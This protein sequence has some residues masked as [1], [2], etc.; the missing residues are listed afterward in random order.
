MY[1]VFL[2]ESTPFGLVFLKNYGAQSLDEYFDLLYM[3]VYKKVCILYASVISCNNF[4][5]KK[6]FI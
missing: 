1:D 2:V 5:K 3:F 4:M 6:E